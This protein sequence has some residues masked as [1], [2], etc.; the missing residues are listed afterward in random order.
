MQINNQ[1]IVLK[2]VLIFETSCQSLRPRWGRKDHRTVYKLLP[3][4]LERL[5]RDLEHPKETALSLWWSIGKKEKQHCFNFIYNV[6]AVL[7]SLYTCL[8]LSVQ[9]V[10]YP[11]WGNFTC[12]KKWYLYTEHTIVQQY[13]HADE[14]GLL[15]ME[16]FLLLGPGCFNLLPEERKGVFVLSNVGA[17]AGQRASEGNVALYQ[18]PSHDSSGCSQCQNTSTGRCSDSSPWRWLI[19]TVS[20]ACSCACCYSR[21]IKERTARRMTTLRSAKLHCIVC[22]H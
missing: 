12:S 4:Q 22:S 17:P 3:W 18:P 2:T 5:W 7:Y 21:C 6:G 16:E 19:T 1:G 10:H 15:H 11:R 8:T 9:S 13:T 14:A 20:S